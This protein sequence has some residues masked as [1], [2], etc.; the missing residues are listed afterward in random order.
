LDP[1]IFLSTAFSKPSSLCSLYNVRNRV[2]PKSVIAHISKQKTTSTFY[3]H[4]Q[5]R[6][7]NQY[8]IRFCN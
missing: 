7:I 3:T 8:L 2:T 6:T 5:I 4:K 1:N